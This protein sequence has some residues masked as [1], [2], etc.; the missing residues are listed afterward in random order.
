MDN[1]IQL[2]AMLFSDLTNEII[3]SLQV[4]N[5]RMIPKN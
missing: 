5:K 3:D 2:S 4:R 1:E